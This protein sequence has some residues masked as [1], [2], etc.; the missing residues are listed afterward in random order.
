MGNFL[1]S[2]QVETLNPKM[3]GRAGIG[4]Y[5]HARQPKPAP[6][7]LMSHPPKVGVPL[8]NPEPMEVWGLPEVEYLLLVRW[9][10][11]LCRSIFLHWFL[12]R[13]N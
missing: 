12:L 8:P 9:R 1:W 4:T 3:M 13:R 10:N 6:P 7:C 5:S 11:M 2:P